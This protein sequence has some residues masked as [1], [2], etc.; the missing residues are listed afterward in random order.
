MNEKLKLQKLWNYLEV[1]DN[2]NLI[3]QSYNH[4]KGSDEFFVVESVKNELKITTSNSLPELKADKPFILVQQIDSTG[5]H[6]IPSVE[7]LKNDE[8][9]DY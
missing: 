8:L 4:E 6:I 9:I 5:K 3:V 7:Q 1:Q 2:E